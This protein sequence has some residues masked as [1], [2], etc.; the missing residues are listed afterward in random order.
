M[1]RLDRRLE[2]S[3]TLL[4]LVVTVAMLGYVGYSRFRRPGV[5]AVDP[6]LPREAISTL[7]GVH[8]GAA[9]ADVVVLEYSD[10][11]CPACRTFAVDTFPK[12]REHFIGTERVV[13]VARSFPAGHTDTLGL[14]TA[15][16]ARCLAATPQ[17]WPFREALFAREVDPRR[18]TLES[19]LTDLGRI[20]GSVGVDSGSFNSCL[21]KQADVDTLAEI[22]S[23]RLLDVTATPTFFLGR[24]EGDDLVRLSRRIVGAI[25]FAELSAELEALLKR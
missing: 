22:G 23:G 14:R 1:E 16:T 17:F 6:P 25:P 10:F 11:H 18:E 5:R 20:A 15:T 8:L 7:Q 24:R 3:V 9:A 13:W 2:V 19:G 12:I 21:N 4:M